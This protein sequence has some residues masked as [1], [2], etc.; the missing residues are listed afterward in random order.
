MNIKEHKAACDEI[1]RICGDDIN[2]GIGFLVQMILD[3]QKF[4]F[5]AGIARVE[6]GETKES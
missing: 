3:E 4:E 6:D 1:H 2:M 5:K